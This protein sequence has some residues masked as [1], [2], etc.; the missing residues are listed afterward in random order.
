MKMLCRTT[1]PFMLYNSASGIEID[2][3]GIGITK[4][5]GWASNQINQGQLEILSSGLA[6]EVMNE[7]VQDVFAQFDGDIEAT[8]EY[9]ET[10]YPWGEEYPQELRTKAELDSVVKQIMRNRAQLD[11]DKAKADEAEKAKMEADEAEKAKMEADEAEKAKMEADAKA[12]ADEAEKAE[13]KAQMKAD[14][15]AEKDAKAKAKADAKAAAKAEKDAT[16][17]PKTE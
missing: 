16:T 11:A 2:S 4:A 14:A 9:F 8:I 7:E 5:G 13:I 1:G 12:K 15:Q 6:D 10:S 17:A 3:I